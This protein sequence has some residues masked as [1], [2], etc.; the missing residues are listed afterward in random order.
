MKKKCLPPAGFTL[1]ELLLA[2][3][4]MSV[5]LVGL[6]QVFIQCSVLA[7]M[8]RNKTIALSE[9][10]GKIEEIRNYDYDAIATDYVLNG[11]LNPFDLSQLTG[12]GVIYIDSTNTELLEVE[13]VISWEDK[14]DRIIGED[15]DLDG[16]VDTGEDINSNSQ[17]DS[18]ATLTTYIAKR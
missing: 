10:Q 11:G 7:E 3:I 8:A 16:V 4:I 1:V 9:A 2:T 17:L 18:I 12:K 5:V 14:Y 15:L 13:V 6:I